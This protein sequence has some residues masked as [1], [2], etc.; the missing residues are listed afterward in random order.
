MRLS[1]IADFPEFYLLR[2]LAAE[3]NQISRHMATLRQ[4]HPDYNPEVFYLA[5]YLGGYLLSAALVTGR[6]LRGNQRLDWRNP[7][8]LAG[9]MREVYLTALCAFTARTR[10]EILPW[11]ELADWERFAR[12]MAFFMAEGDGYADYLLNRNIP[13]E[14]YGLDVQVRYSDNYPNSRGW[15]NT[16]QRKGWY[17]D[18]QNPD[19]GP[20]N[21]PNPLQELIRANY[22]LNVFM[23]RPE[24][25][26]PGVTGPDGGRTVG[27]ASV[28][29]MQVLQLEEEAQ[30]LIA[31]GGIRQAISVLE[32]ALANA[33]RLRGQIL[34]P[35]GSVV[36]GKINELSASLASLRQEASAQTGQPSIAQ[37]ENPFGGIDFRSLPIVT[38][39]IGN[40]RVDLNDAALRRLSNVN[41]DEE[42]TRIERMINSGITPSSQRIKEYLQASCLN[43]NSQQD[44]NK[45]ILCISDILRQEEVNCVST[46]PMLRD[47]LVLLESSSQTQELREIFLGKVSK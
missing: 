7:A 18:G 4:D 13:P 3:G 5:S 16:G 9:I 11:L 21:G 33:R 41:L 31:E 19:L 25:L 28:W 12:Q 42:L 1:G 20:V 39:A 22:L 36:A 2:D 34:I 6:Y 29:E 26:N 35:D 10:E 17:F 40:L 38:Q 37:T 43:G 24:L 27:A 45:I 44:I 46:E 47:I 32:E 15:V 23:L 14:I 30:A 8:E